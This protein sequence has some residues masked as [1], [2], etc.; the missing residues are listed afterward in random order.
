MPAAMQDN[1][2]G[3][4]DLVG[5]FARD[6]G[7]AHRILVARYNEGRTVDQSVI[8]LLSMR[9]RLA[10]RLGDRRSNRSSIVD[11]L[12]Y[13]PLS[14][15]R[16]RR[17]LHSLP[18]SELIFVVWRAIIGLLPFIASVMLRVTALLCAS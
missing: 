12:P 4:A 5:K 6:S 14:T 15:N 17:D 8:G 2:S 16:D 3:A 11:P 1:R 18:K 10:A 9:E 13:S 7:R